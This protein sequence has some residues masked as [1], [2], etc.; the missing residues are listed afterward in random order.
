[1]KSHG[2]LANP[3]QSVQ[4]TSGISAALQT[5]GA[6]TQSDSNKTERFYHLEKGELLRL[7][8]RYKESTT[9]FLVADSRVRAWEESAKTHLQ[10]LLGTLDTA[11]V[12]IERTHEPGQKALATWGKN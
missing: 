8:R 7:H 10:K 9:A 11:R 3:M 1:M 12:G 5:L 4:Q 2:A 6:S